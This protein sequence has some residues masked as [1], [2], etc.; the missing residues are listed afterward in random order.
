MKVLVTTASKHGA[1]AEIGAM[2]AEVLRDAGLEVTETPASDVNSV[3]EYEAVVLG[4][5]VYAGRWLGEARELVKRD[6]SALRGRMVWLFSSGP[7]GDP[8]KPVADPADVPEV[9]ELS[10]AIEHVVFAGRIDRSELGLG[11]RA[12]VALVKAPDGDFR[13]WAEVR[14]WAGRV[15]EHLAKAAPQPVAAGG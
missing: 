1:T 12:I 10:G 7:V 3:A 13:Q 9:L 8:P 5:G 2:I 11:E 15:A 6:S 14:E 4:S